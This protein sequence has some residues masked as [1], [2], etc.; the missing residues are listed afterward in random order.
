[1]ATNRYNNS[2]VY[3]LVNDCDDEVYVGST[4]EP[5][6]KRLYKHKQKSKLCPDRRVYQ[7]ILNVGWDTVH[8][9]LIESFSCN[10]KEELLRR[11]RHYIDELRPTL[12]MCLPLRT[13][14]EWR[15]ENKE[16]LKEKAKVYR[17]E[18]IEVIKE[19]DRAR[20]VQR[21]DADN[22]RK[23]EK[24]ES[25]EAYREEVNAR[26]REK[27]AN[28]EEFRD[29]DNARQREKWANNRDAINARR[30]ETRADNRE[31]INA[32]Q[33]EKR[34]NDEAYR[35]AVRAKDR[36]RY[37]KKQSVLVKNTHLTN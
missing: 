17:T 13:F 3:K 23:R 11:E 20:W 1:M 29:A 27:R 24:R 34:A 14:H 16:A 5:L 6:H 37:A 12:N 35:E 15:T 30:R 8:I 25:D 2:K 36:E 18:N 32:R 26:V 7:H 33:R 4:T 28:D 21:R 10:S 31:A 9:V 22:A 19:K